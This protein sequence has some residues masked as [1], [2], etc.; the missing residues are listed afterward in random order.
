MPT[1]SSNWVN[2]HLSHR[3]HDRDAIATDYC[4][5]ILYYIILFT[6]V[7]RIAIRIIM[8]NA[9]INMNKFISHSIW[10]FSFKKYACHA[11]KTGNNHVQNIWIFWPL[12]G[13][14]FMV[15]YVYSVT[16][17]TCWLY[18]HSVICFFVVKGKRSRSS[19]SN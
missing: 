7:R 6:Y 11:E 14:L 18:M 1:S 12:H 15:L 10:W 8:Q 16:Y 13:A 5:I 9:R 3:G 2:K 4:Y 19:I 17:N